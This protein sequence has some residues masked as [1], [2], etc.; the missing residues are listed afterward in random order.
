MVSGSKRVL[1]C[2]DSALMRKLIA[3][4]LSAVGWQVA[5]EASD[6]DEAVQQYQVLRPDA[7]TMDIVMPGVGGIEGLNRIMRLD[8]TA[9]VVV[10]SALN[11]TKAIAEAIRHGAQDFIVK[12]FMPEQLQQTMENCLTGGNGKNGG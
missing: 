6:G 4:S 8:P 11:Q 7:V 2:D 10:V 3:D 1:I 9:K 5:G 12:P